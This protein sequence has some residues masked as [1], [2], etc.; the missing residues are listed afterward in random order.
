MATVS[1]M[2]TGVMVMMTVETT[3]M[4]LDVVVQVV[5]VCTYNL[6]VHCTVY[7]DG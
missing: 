6:H 1:Q 7:T 4:K 2:V 5:Q 3:V